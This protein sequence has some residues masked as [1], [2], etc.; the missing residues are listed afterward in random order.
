[1]INAV[2]ASAFERQGDLI[3]HREIFFL[4]ARTTMV[5][6][7]DNNSNLNIPI[8]Y[9]R[10]RKSRSRRG[11]PDV[12]AETLARWKEYNDKLQ[13]SN[14]GSK[15]VRKVPA[16][17]S[18]KGCMKGKGGPQNTEC[19]YRGVRQRTWGKWVAEIRE[20]NR[21]SRLWLGT[22][23]TAGEAALAYNEAAKAMY[24]PLARLNVVNGDSLSEYSKESTSQ[25][26]ISGSLSEYSKES[27]SQPTISGSDSTNS[28]SCSEV[29]KAEDLKENIE[30]SSSEVC[31][32]EDLK[33]NIKPSSPVRLVK[34][35]V[36]EEPV[37]FNG[38]E[39]EEKLISGKPG[40]DYK[41]AFS[42]N[43]PADEMFD[44][45]EL[46][47]VLDKD[48][49]SGLS[50]Y[51]S[52]MGQPDDYSNLQDEKPLDL[53]YQLQNPDA[54]LLGSLPHMDQAPSGVDYG[55]D[56]LRP[57]R[58]DDYNFDF[59]EFGFLDLDLDMGLN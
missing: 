15:P 48:Y 58:E 37:D 4:I 35:E 44:V 52:K 36:K 45:D 17:G 38:S 40:L 29:C 31:G 20:P 50:Q 56:F 5:G 41:P 55:F 42:E 1:M 13:S 54:K 30:P 51:L 26:T 18:K 11:G 49:K 34:K 57:E 12:V 22:F 19:N 23:P 47:G 46:L 24:G 33:E 25:P 16:K 14:G 59:D 27:T 10:K 9:T 7:L 39:D 21:G 8:D 3:K 28:S 43:F 32:A 6:L 2:T 53:S